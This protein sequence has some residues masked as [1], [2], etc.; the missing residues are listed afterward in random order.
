[1]N[2]PTASVR[3]H[4]LAPGRANRAIDASLGTTPYARM[5]PEL[6]SFQADEEF[7]HALGRA[8]GLCDCGD[9]EDTPDSLA[10]VAAGWPIFGQFV[11]HDITADRSRLRVHA[12][13]AE[14]H[15]ARS[16]KLN[17]ETL[18][19]DGPTGHP[20]LYQREDPAKFL[21]GP[22][23]ADIQRN[24]EGTAVIGDPRNDSHML[25]SQLHLAVLKAHNAFVDDARL[26][27]V[28]SD[29]VFDEAANRG[30]KPGM[31]RP[32]PT[33]VSSNTANDFDLPN[34][35]PR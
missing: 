34:R 25:I 24:A 18:Y 35:N 9:V 7:L 19:G 2:Q 5:F 22:D 6:P 30:P 3:N 15:N 29:D 14:L 20:F 17:L 33:G 27:G 12:N 23:G 4:C 11:A 8:G 32:G 28:S 1:M 10:D 16:P 26:A 21:L 13:T 31:S